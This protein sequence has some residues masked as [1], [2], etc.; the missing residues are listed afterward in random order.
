[1][2]MLGGI[3]SKQNGWKA[4]DF[5]VNYMLFIKDLDPKYIYPPD[6]ENT[7]R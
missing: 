5:N 6:L 3:E 1:M 2:N 4:A 7:R